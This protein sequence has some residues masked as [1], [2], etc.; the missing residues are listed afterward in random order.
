[1]HLASAADSLATCTLYVCVFFPWGKLLLICSY[2]PDSIFLF[3]FQFLPHTCTYMSFPASYF[4]RDQ[5]LTLLPIAGLTS[6]SYFSWH[7]SSQ[8]DIQSLI[9]LYVS[10]IILPQFCML[11][12]CLWWEDR[13]WEKKPPAQLTASA[14]YALCF[15]LVIIPWSVPAFGFPIQIIWISFLLLLQALMCGV[16]QCNCR[17]LPHG[18]GS[19]KHLSHVGFV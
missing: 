10:I 15:G 11:F 6:L 1:M 4:L 18:W 13:E 8:S 14:P 17:L 16:I 5:R 7:R 2:F 19:N 12:P 3:S 9:L